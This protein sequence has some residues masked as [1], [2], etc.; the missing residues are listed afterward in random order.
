M[1]YTSLRKI[2]FFAKEI[3]PYNCI[4]RHIQILHKGHRLLDILTQVILAGI[5]D[6]VLGCERAVVGVVEPGLG[7]GDIAVGEAVDLLLHQGL[8]VLAAAV[9]HE[10]LDNGAGLIH[11]AAGGLVLV[12]IT[13]LASDRFLGHGMSR[14]SIVHGYNQAGGKKALPPA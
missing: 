12:A 8:V 1:S 13:V 2:V 5:E 14:F 3:Y 4:N 9:H 11:V 6:R 10:L 7:V